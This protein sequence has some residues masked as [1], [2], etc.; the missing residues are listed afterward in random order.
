MKL[1]AYA[2]FL[3]LA[4]WGVPAQVPGGASPER[5]VTVWGPPKAD[6][7]MESI[8]KAT[9]PK[10]MITR[11]TV[12]G[13][14]IKLEETE[15]ER[16]RM[17]FGLVVGSRGDASEALSWICFQGSDEGGPWALWLYNSE[18]D[19]AE[20]G[21]FQWQ[22]ILPNFRVDRRCKSLDAQHGVVE[23]PVR[24]Y[25]GMAE[26]EVDAVLGPPSGKRH[27]SAIYSHEHSLTLHDLPYTVDNDLLITYNSGRVAMIAV[28]YTIAS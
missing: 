17:H 4:G 14:P 10:E 8:L 3:L 26:S 13:W 5:K 16:A 1:L 18:I 15:L 24:L 23:L 22:R 6:W 21:G 25:L 27:N 20:I 2:A 12:A 11:L 7:P 9:V 19:G 28:N